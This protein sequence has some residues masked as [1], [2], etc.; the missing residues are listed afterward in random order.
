M[1]KE[2]N[3][4]VKKHII[5]NRQFEKRMIKLAFLHGLDIQGWEEVFYE[6][7]GN[8]LSPA[9]LKDDAKSKQTLYVNPRHITGGRGPTSRPIDLANIGHKVSYQSL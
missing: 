1:T 9:D 8:P 6:R 5:L 3:P 4:F 7:N 2:T